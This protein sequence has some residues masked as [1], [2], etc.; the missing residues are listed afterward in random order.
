MLPFTLCSSYNF[1]KVLRAL[2]LFGI[3]DSDSNQ[4]FV[5]INP[6]LSRNTPASATDHSAKGVVTIELDPE[7]LKRGIIDPQMV[8]SPTL[9]L[10]IDLW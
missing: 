7:Q 5:S 3:M 10:K 1:P 9:S 2:L 8:G 4:E 6:Q